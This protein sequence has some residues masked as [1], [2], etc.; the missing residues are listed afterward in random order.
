MA[1]LLKAIYRLDVI[2]IKIPTYFIIELE[3][4][5]WNSSGKKTS[6]EKTIFNDQRTSGGNQHLWPYAVLQSN[7][8]KICMVLVKRQAD[9][10]VEQNLSPRNEHIHL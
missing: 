6:R 8:G 4:V 3:R 7:T 5:I 9:R 1:I 10:L 2:L